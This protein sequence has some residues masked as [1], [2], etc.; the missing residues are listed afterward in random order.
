MFSFSFCIYW[1]KNI[2][3][4]ID[5]SFSLI[6][7]NG[8]AKLTSESMVFDNEKTIYF[9]THVK[10]LGKMCIQVENQFVINLFLKRVFVFVVLFVFF[11]CFVPHKDSY[12]IFSIDYH[13]NKFSSAIAYSRAPIS[14]NYIISYLY[15][16]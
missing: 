13:E 6:L 10:P 15:S 12:D 14:P 2:V 9:K 8:T 3:S 4:F 7:Q 5:R 16:F 11:F 1:I